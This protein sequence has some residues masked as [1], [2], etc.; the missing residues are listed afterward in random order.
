MCYETN[1]KIKKETRNSDDL[2]RQNSQKQLRRICNWSC[3]NHPQREKW[4]WKSIFVIYFFLNCV[5][6]HII[7]FIFA[8]VDSTCLILPVMKL[9]FVTVFVSLWE[10]CSLAVDICL[11]CLFLSVSESF[12]SLAVDICFCHMFV[13]SVSFRCL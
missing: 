8:W 11:Y 1:R 12:C 7:S 6:L 4:F 2:S 10:F 3:M 13:L 5:V 9:I